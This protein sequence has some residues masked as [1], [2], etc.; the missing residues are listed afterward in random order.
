MKSECVDPADDYYIL[1]SLKPPS[2]IAVAHNFSN[3]L[4]KILTTLSINT[5]RR[6]M[7]WKKIIAEIFHRK[8]KV[9]RKKSMR[10]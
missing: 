4:E 5:R 2:E 9:K 6:M 8:N 10:L 3:V 1:A 7:C